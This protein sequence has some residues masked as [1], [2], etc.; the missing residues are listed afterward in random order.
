LD[1]QRIANIKEHG[2]SLVETAIIT[3]L[4][5]VMLLGVFEVGSAIRAYI[6]LLNA[7]REAARFLA[8][9]LYTDDQG[10]AHFNRSLSNAMHSD[11]SNTTVYIRRFG[12]EVGNPFTYADDVYMDTLRVYGSLHP[13]SVVV[14]DLLGEAL[15]MSSDVN[16]V[17]YN[18]E[19]A[20]ACAD[21]LMQ[22]RCD[23]LE[24]HDFDSAPV[25]WH[26]EEFLSV[27]TYYSHSQII[28]LFGEFKLPLYVQTMMRISRSRTN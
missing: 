23:A 6:V 24:R 4:L 16:L 1:K 19:V 13:S 10:Y 17:Q 27:E 12:V 15:T 25:D 2:Q 20:M 3:P 28:G 7:N 5:L 26:T 8:R 22:N 14:G 9:G 18:R 11:T 21:T